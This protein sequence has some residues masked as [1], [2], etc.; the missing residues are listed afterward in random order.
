[1][2]NYYK[3]W[4]E[5]RNEANSLQQNQAAYAQLAKLLAVRLGSVPHI[6]VQPHTT[7]DQQIDS[8]R[9]VT[10]I[11]SE[12]TAWHMG[13]LLDRIGAQQTAIQFE[14]GEHAPQQNTS[15]GKK[16]ALPDDG[17]SGAP[18]KKSRIRTCPRCKRSG[19][20]GAFLSRPCG[21]IDLVCVM[22]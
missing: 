14:Y 21:P 16:R 8:S 11:P 15:K 6:P 20:P 3:T 22:Q 1:M 10:Q 18:V 17:G 4:C 5:N 19:C 2:K 13:I 9:R 12:I 7:L